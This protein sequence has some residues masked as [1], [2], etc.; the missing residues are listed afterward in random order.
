[1]P[2]RKIAFNTKGYDGFI[3]FIKA[4]AIICVLF[5]HT[6]GPYLDKTAYGV[7]A[8]M[9]VPLFILIQCF[10]SFKRDKVELNLLKVFKRVLL[11]FFLIEIVTFAIAIAIDLYS[12]HTLLRMALAGGAG[13]GAY[14]PWIYVQIAV[15]LPFFAILLKRYNTIQAGFIFLLICEGFELL[16]SFIGM[17][18]N[19]YRLLAI[20]YIFL[21]YFGWIWVHNG[22]VVNWKTILL[23]LLS[24]ATIVYFEYYSNNIE[25]WF[26]TTGFSYHR[27]P[28]Y[29]FVAYGFSMFLNVLWKGVRQN[30]IMVKGVR[31]LSI[32]SYEIFLVQMSLVFL[33]PNDVEEKTPTLS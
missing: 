25:P 18:E 9:Q 15:L 10:H 21:I 2:E 7:W 22:I 23:S 11:P 6:F 26:F 3:D 13:P 19:L 32:S 14:F 1:M 17:P 31:I 12:F 16:I 8:G 28:C 30:K 33:L 24:L 27:W 4:Y 20:R 29:F 5:G